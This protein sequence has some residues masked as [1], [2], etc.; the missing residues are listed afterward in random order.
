MT[1]P[2]TFFLATKPGLEPVLAA[3]ARALGLTVAAQDAGGVTCTGPLKDLWRA[4]LCLRI[5]DRVMLRIA[6]FRAMHPAQLD[7]RA[8]KIDWRGVLP[9]GARLRIEATCRASRIYHEGAARSRVEKAARAAL[10]PAREEAPAFRLSLRILDDLCT[11]SLDTSG[12]PL[13]KRGHKQAVG[14][15]PMRETLAAAFLTQCG[16]DGRETVV[17]PMCGSGTFP[18]EAAEIAAGLYP[19]RARSFA[20]QAMP[21]YDPSLFEALKSDALPTQARFFGSDRND[22]A[23]AM[24]SA[25]A[26]RAGVGDACRFTRAAISDLARPDTAPGLILVNPPY[27]G[28]IGQRK[29]LFALYGSLG[30]VLKD[31]FKG[32]R[33]GLVTS[34]AGLAKA[35]GLQLKGGPEIP[36]GPLKIR[37]WQSGTLG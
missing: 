27:G 33:L 13:H 3:E 11:V 19:G 30:Q 35:T 31:R 2:C 6:E 32:W 36:H 5:P 20:F 21:G 7:K 4:N 29:L 22:G 12:E 9:E 34:D 17:D 18:I 26:K 28:R 8:R 10:G 15:A 23:V 25:N 16:Y 24:A 1:E 14:K 37:L